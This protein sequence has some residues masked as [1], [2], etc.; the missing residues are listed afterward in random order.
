MTTFTVQYAISEVTVLSDVLCVHQALLHQAEDP[1][2][3]HR[4]EIC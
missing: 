3:C 2:D 4:G 1:T